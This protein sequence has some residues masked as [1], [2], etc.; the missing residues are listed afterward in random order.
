MENELKKRL[1]TVQERIISAC[2]K[3]GRSVQSVRLIAVTKTHPA[4]ILQKLIDLGIKDLGENRVQEIQAKVPRL[5]GEFTMH[6]IGHLQTNKV[7]KVLPLV[8]WIQSIDR[9]PLIAKIE[10]Q[11]QS[12]EKIN[13]LLEVNSSGEVSK[14]GCDPSQCRALAERIAGSPALKFCGLMTIGPLEGGEVA[15]RRSFSLLRELGEQCSDLAPG[16]ELS[17][18]MSNDFEWA[19]QEGS[20][21]V[22]IGSLL[23]GERQ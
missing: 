11:H 10:K 20:T 16:I 19:I 12:A 2:E 17:M 14:S 21:M 6:L 4:E 5:K 23:L 13:A 9:E 22:R 3:S 7:S 8:K 1:E 18:G 15:V